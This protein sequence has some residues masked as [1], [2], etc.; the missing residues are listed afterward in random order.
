VGGERSV[1]VCVTMRLVS[2]DGES[3]RILRV[4]SEC[5]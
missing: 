4:E 3:E 2:E 5:G 1:C